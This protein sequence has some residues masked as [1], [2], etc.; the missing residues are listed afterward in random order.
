MAKLPGLFQREGVYQLRVIIPKGVQRA[1]SGTK[2]R[3]ESL[4]TSD[5]Q[6]AKVVAT[7]LRATRLAEAQRMTAAVL[8]NDETVRSDPAIAALLLNTIEGA[9]PPSPL[10]IGNSPPRTPFAAPIDPLEGLSEEL[11]GGLTQLNAGMDRQA[12]LH[13]S[14]QRI[15]AILADSPG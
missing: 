13:N 8:R 11:A 12:A 7:A 2:K 14:I 15:A 4:G 1:Y 5:Y 3:V 10:L 9:L 6:T